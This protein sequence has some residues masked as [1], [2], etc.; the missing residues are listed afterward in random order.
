MTLSEIYSTIFPLDGIDN[1][2]KYAN[3][4]SNELNTVQLLE[5]VVAVTEFVVK[6]KDRATINALPDRMAFRLP[7]VAINSNLIHMESITNFYL[8]YS[9][10]I[11]SIMVEF[12]DI[13]NELLSTNSIRDGSIIKVYIGG[14]GDEL[15]YKPIRQDF[16]ITNVIKMNSGDQN[17]GEWLQY[18]LTGTLNVPMGNRKES[19]CNS[20]STSTQELFNLAVYTGLGFATNFTFTTIDKMSWINSLGYSYFEF[21]Q[22]I[23]NHACYS[24]N[25]F[26][27]AFIDQ[28]YV[29]NFVECHSLLSHGGDKKD[30]PAIIYSNYQDSSEPNID[31]SK[32]DGKNEKTTDQI[33]VDKNLKETDLNN[34]SQKLSYYFLSNHIYFK[35][36]SNYIESYNEI[37]DGYSTMDDGYR[38]NL[39]YSDC[40][41]AGWGS[42]GKWSIPPIDNLDREEDTQKIKSL[43]NKADED[44]YIPLNLMQMNNFEYQKDGVTSIDKMSEVESFVNF[45]QVDTTN[46]YKQYYFAEIQNEYQMKCM[47]KCG[48][49][50]TL[51][52]YNPSITK[53]SR[54]WVDIYDM[55]P[56]SN[57]SIKKDNDIKE[58]TAPKN[59]MD[60]YRKY[61]NDNI[62]SFKG[63]GDLDIVV[64]QGEK[65]NSQNSPRG[66]YNRSLSGWYV[67]TELKIT[68]DNYNKNL[69]TH[70][71]LNRIE[72]KPL[73]QSEFELAQKAIDKYK[74][75][76]LVE[77]I[78][79][80]I[81]DFSYNE[82]EN[83][84]DTTK[85]EETTN[86][87]NTTTKEN[88]VNI[89]MDSSGALICDFNNPNG[90]KT[91]NSFM[92]SNSLYLPNI[93]LTPNKPSYLTPTPN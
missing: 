90:N 51:Q 41:T 83:S 65:P 64:K 10:F 60:E 21:M 73:Y 57:M 66:Y 20:P 5:P 91:I 33:T 9:S 67:V 11:P 78:F 71:L 13:N 55:N 25:T 42:S 45:G 72:H 23:A 19:W 44:T 87:D 75:E 63:E 36:W 18:R 54:I 16:I 85:S 6:D 17:L 89:K 92:G 34:D 88:T 62:I 35:G 53:F 12:I 29:L 69:K 40:N 15:Y 4:P 86:T 93:Q 49:S 30:T 26:F 59:V 1:N 3:M 70:V 39:V 81:D 68:Y 77:C 8:D 84:T 43:P 2:N 37:S 48:L 52:N 24:P 28:Y 31:K 14:N 80:N 76:N 50:V 32:N 47:K 22:N 74:E 7:L 82:T 38:K 27:T 61:L 56:Q 46:M 79:N 58:A